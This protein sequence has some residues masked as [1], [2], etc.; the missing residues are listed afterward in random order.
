MNVRKQVC[1]FFGKRFR[2]KAATRVW[3]FFKRA[4]PVYLVLPSAVLYRLVVG[5]AVRRRLLVT[6]PLSREQKTLLLVTTIVRFI[7]GELKFRIQKNTWYTWTSVKQSNNLGPP[8]SAE[9]LGNHHA[10]T[11]DLGALSVYIHSRMLVSKSYF[12]IFRCGDRI[13]QKNFARCK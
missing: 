8:S 2:N 13:A 5:L 12:I 11:H 6:F 1:R 3:L 7:E 9:R 10:R 4:V